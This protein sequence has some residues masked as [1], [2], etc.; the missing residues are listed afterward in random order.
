[1][2]RGWDCPSAHT[3]GLALA[4]IIPKNDDVATGMERKEMDG[5]PDIFWS[6]EPIMGPKGTKENPAIIPSFNTSRCVGLAA[7]LSS[8]GRWLEAA[9]ERLLFEQALSVRVRVGVRVGVRVR[10]RVGVGLRGW[11]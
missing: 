8:C 9:E 11:E 5:D 4:G 1:M 3:P 7:A 6:R 2:R 10:V